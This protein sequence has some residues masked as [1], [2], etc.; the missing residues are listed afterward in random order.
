MEAIRCDRCGEY[1]EVSAFRK[2]AAKYKN[3]H[4]YMYGITSEAAYAT[5]TTHLDLC[6]DCTLSLETWMNDGHGK[7]KLQE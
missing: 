3:E 5:T 2:F 4:Q 6:P 7:L 1:C